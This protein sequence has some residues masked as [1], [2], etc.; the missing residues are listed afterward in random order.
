MTEHEAVKLKEAEKTR[1]YYWVQVQAQKDYRESQ[2]L[3]DEEW[4]RQV[5]IKAERQRQSLHISDLA[6]S[7]SNS[8]LKYLSTQEMKVLMS[9]GDSIQGGEGDGDGDSDD[10]LPSLTTVLNSQPNLLVGIASS[11][12]IGANDSPSATAPGC[13]TRV[14]RQTRKKELQN[15]H[16]AV[17]ARLKGQKKVERQ[18]ALER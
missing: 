18:E 11:S 5:Q 10:D 17:A 4:E 15:N 9:M 16:K 3:L 6:D 8:E 2:R 12:G 1:C 7:D 14:R 13:L